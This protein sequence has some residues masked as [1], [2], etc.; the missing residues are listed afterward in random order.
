MNKNVSKKNIRQKEKGGAKSR[1]SNSPGK[2]ASGSNMVPKTQIIVRPDVNKLRAKAAA[3]LLALAI[4]NPTAFS[5]DGG[6]K[7]MELINP[8]YYGFGAKKYRYG[9]LNA[10]FHTPVSGEPGYGRC[11]RQAGVGENEFFLTSADPTLTDLNASNNL[12]FLGHYVGQGVNSNFPNFP[13]PDAKSGEIYPFIIKDIGA[14]KDMFPTKLVNDPV[15]SFTPLQSFS[16]LAGT[17]VAFD[18]AVELNRPSTNAWAMQFRALSST[19]V[20]A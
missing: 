16:R 11:F 14:K 8:A 13:I 2:G 9:E 20:V 12:A 17:A 18:Y 3:Y 15:E 10:E 5:G 1:G 4:L 7:L 19:G 6:K